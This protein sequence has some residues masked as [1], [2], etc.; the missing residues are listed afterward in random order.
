[1]M[2]KTVESTKI[3]DSIYLQYG[4]KAHYLN[5]SVEHHKLHEDEDVKEAR[6]SF[7]KELASK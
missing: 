5:A 2:I 1:M 6:A 3:H 4:Y 7:Q